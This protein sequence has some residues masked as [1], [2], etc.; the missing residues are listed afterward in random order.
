MSLPGSHPLSAMHNPDHPFHTGEPY[1]PLELLTEYER[2]L[3]IGH[4]IQE[5]HSGMAVAYGM[6]ALSGALVAT[7]LTSL[8]WW[9]LG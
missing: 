4:S 2:L 3:A 8:A 1:S 9:W 5:P 6:C 7:L